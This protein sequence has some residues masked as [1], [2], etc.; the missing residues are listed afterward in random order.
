METRGVTP[1]LVA[2]IPLAIQAF[3]SRGILL[4]SGVSLGEAEAAGLAADAT[5]IPCLDFLTSEDVG[6]GHQPS[7]RFEEGDDETLCE[8]GQQ[9]TAEGK[10]KA[11]WNLQSL[12]AP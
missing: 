11:L 9:G 5:P 10:S 2:N 4:L 12:L 8:N 7:H 3:A 1:Y 6:R